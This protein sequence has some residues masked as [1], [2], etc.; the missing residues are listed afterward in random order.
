MNI[1]PASSS[2][3]SFW[4]ISLFTHCPLCVPAAHLCFP[5]FQ[6]SPTL[7]QCR[8]SLHHHQLPITLKQLKSIDR[9]PVCIYSVSR[10]I[11]SYGTG[12]CWIKFTNHM[13][14][15]PFSHK[16][17]I[18]HTIYLCQCCVHPECHGQKCLHLFSDFEAYHEQMGPIPS[19]NG[20]SDIALS[21]AHT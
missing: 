12:F 21:N 14:R 18:R 15:K 11:H 8:L 17:L 9:L 16:R 13:N 10:Q 4:E 2:L 19:S 7:T 20:S 1:W 3:S 6:V 5:G